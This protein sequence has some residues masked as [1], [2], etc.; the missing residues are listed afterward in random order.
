LTRDVIRRRVR[1]H[2]RVQGVFF[3]DS[4]RREAEARGVAGWASNEPD[5][6]VEAVFEGAPADVDELV[7]WC[8]SGPRRANVR[9][10]EVTDDVLYYV[11]APPEGESLRDRLTRER[12][13]PIEEALRIAEDVATAL[14]R[15]ARAGVWHGDLRPKHVALAPRGAVVGGFGVVEALGLYSEREGQSAV[16]LLGEPAYLS[17]E[18]LA[19]ERA[20][21][22]RS[23]VYALACVLYHM[24]VGEPPFGAGVRQVMSRKLTEPAPSPR[25]ARESVPEALD[26]LVRRCLA[27]T[28]ADRFRSG[29]ELRGE[30]ARLR[31]SA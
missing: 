24:L 18:Q 26:A 20:P 28:P 25:A 17:P 9:D 31:E 13:L 6:S 15:A 14:Q 4:V 30:I 27:R 11:T 3:R 1:A 19:A 5:G 12:Q 21:D 8:R 2:G 10:V 7:A 22:E 29:A 23:D 16:V